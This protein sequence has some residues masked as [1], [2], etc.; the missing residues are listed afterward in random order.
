MKSSTN[1]GEAMTENRT[2]LERRKREHRLF[3]LFAAPWF[4]GFILFTI[5]PFAASFIISFYRWN[6]VEAPIYVG[7]EN[8]QDV[9]TDPLVIHSIKVTF[10]YALISVPLN[11][12]MTFAVALLLN[13]DIKYASTFRTI[14]YL[15][16]VLSGVAMAFLWSYVFNHHFGL[17]NSF[18]R[19]VGV[20]GPNW[21]GDPKWTL[22]TVMIMNLW[23]AGG[24]IFMYLAGLQAVPQHLIE[25][26]KLSGAGYWT[27]LFKIVL[28]S[29][30][31]VIQF[32]L[33][34]GIIGALQNF[35]SAYILVGGGPAN[36]TLFFGMYIYNNAYSYRKFGKA[37]VMAWL[38]FLIIFVISKLFLRISSKMVY[39]ENEKGEQL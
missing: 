23:S 16:S 27:R 34:T 38:L 10:K 19:T 21:V 31:P 14:F 7:L 2:V 17:I 5:I 4:I 28:P 36:S 18:L 6:I 15:P 39:Y 24:G 26:A 11:F 9:F 37:C 1:N 12:I 22:V 35:T 33:L 3:N 13:A 8:Y 20:K 30:S 32:S 25:V 29:M